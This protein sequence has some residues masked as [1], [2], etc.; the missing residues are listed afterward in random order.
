[1]KLVSFIVNH[2]NLLCAL[3]LVAAVLVH[4]HRQGINTNVGDIPKRR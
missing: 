3:A 4:C 1:M 2:W